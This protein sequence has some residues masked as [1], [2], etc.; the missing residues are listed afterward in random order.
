MTDLEKALYA[1]EVFL[2]HK[3]KNKEYWLVESMTVEQTYVGEPPSNSVQK[4]LSALEQV[5]RETISVF[6]PG[7]KYSVEDAY[8][9]AKGLESGL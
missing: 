2:K 1:A 9:I 5:G 6:H 3:Y 4:H 8:L 7:I